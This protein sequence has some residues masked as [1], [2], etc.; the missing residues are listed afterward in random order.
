M[1]KQKQVKQKWVKEEETFFPISGNATLYDAPGNGVF[2]LIEEPTMGGSRIG[3]RKIAEKFTFGFKIYDLGMENIMN[4]VKTDWA[5]GKDSSEVTNLGVIFNGLKGTGKTIASKLLANEFNLPVVIIGGP[6]K[7]LVEFMQAICF[8]CVVLVDE[9][10]KT[11]S[12]AGEM[13]LR[14]ID[15]VYN[16]ARKLY[17][18]TTNQLSIDPNLIN[19]PSRIMYLQEFGNLT[20]KAIEDYIKDN[21]KDKS[22]AS[23]VT[24]TVDLLDFSTIDIL[25][26]IVRH[27]NVFG[28]I[29]EKTPLNIPRANYKF[30]IIAFY[31]VPKE[32]YEE[33]KKAV[34]AAK[35]EGKTTLQWW[36][37]DWTNPNDPENK[38]YTT[39]ESIMYRFEDSYPDETVITSNYSSLIRGQHVRIGEIVEEVDKDGF[40]VVKNDGDTEIL[41]VIT[42]YYDAPSLY[43]GKLSVVY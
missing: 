22:K 31:N 33:I 12:E 18:L 14:M 4:L 1:K 37:Q 6:C 7:G 26:A 25:K 42:G 34:H 41:C 24:R 21:L 19:R 39:R 15:G 8:E 35:K 2:Q 32:G 13:L 40:F 43:R 27:V 29:D 9:A 20:E 23:L 28:K 36:K 3:L 11:F 5:A 38:A 16:E 17:I 30:D 10:E